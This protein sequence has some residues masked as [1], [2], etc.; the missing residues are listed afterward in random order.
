MAQNPY[1]LKALLG[2]L[3]EHL[4]NT[5]KEQL[6][7]AAQEEMQ[8]RQVF[9]SMLKADNPELQA[10]GLAGLLEKRGKGW[11]GKLRQSQVMPE[12]ENILNRAQ[13]VA[14]EPQ[15]SKPVGAAPPPQASPTA[16][17]TSSPTTGGQMTMT[18][19]M[20][21]APPPEAMLDPTTTQE[22]IEDIQA[23]LA[24]APPEPPPQMTP[25]PAPEDF[26]ARYR[27]DVESRRRSFHERNPLGTF[28]LAPNEDRMLQAQ[29]LGLSPEEIRT[30]LTAEIFPTS[31]KLQGSR[32]LETLRQ[33]GRQALLESKQGIE[34]DQATAQRLGIPAGTIDR[35]LF[36][37]MERN[38]R[39]ADQ[40]AARRANAQLMMRNYNLR[41]FPSADG[42]GVVAVD[43]RQTPP[44]EISGI[45]YTPASHTES[46]ATSGRLAM[47][48]DAQRVRSLIENNE[49]L[50]GWATGKTQQLA[51][52]FDSANPTWVELDDLLNRMRT[53][54]MYEL[55]GKAAAAWE[56]EGIGRMVPQL[57]TFSASPQ[58]FMQQLAGY[59][60]KVDQFMRMYRGGVNEG[61]PP[62]RPGERKQ[63]NG[64]WYEKKDGAKGRGWYKVQ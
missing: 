44:G 11:F 43:P 16:Q 51:R 2:G 4:T 30:Q 14:T 22:P 38:A 25:P 6:S 40:I 33:Q 15:T 54:Q 17:A 60:R 49:D 62:S 1:F 29:A 53:G 45:R 20:A 39:S 41:F 61:A 47:K 35:D 48:E 3:S 21:P 50:I 46:M 36:K 58:K 27:S 59:E 57:D 7:R 12:V 19:G 18:P 28:E 56:R 55:T 34:I 32:D 52:Y 42:S 63:I 26:A 31:T 13:S 23:R 5:H 24:A 10:L 8:D 9:A 64:V 37:E